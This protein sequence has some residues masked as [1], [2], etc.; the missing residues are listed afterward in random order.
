MGRK[1]H[2]GG[3][4]FDTEGR[5][6]LR[7]PRGHFGRYVWTF[8]KG[9]PEEGESPEETA[10]RETQEETGFAAEVLH[11][12]PGTF[13]G[14]RSDNVYFLM[15]PVGQVSEPDE[16]TATLRWAAPAEARELIRMTKTPEGVKR[17]LDVLEAA[18]RLR[19]RS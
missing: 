8:P 13:L 15:R 1:L 4:L 5:V 11:Q 6:L 3:V 14:T 19:S 18:L 10:L 9:S 16:E 2:Y 12:I 7:E 17:D